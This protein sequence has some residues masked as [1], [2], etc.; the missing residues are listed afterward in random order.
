[1]SRAST[2]AVVH[3]LE[4]RRLL[5]AGDIDLSFGGDGSVEIGATFPVA[6]P[7]VL[8]AGNDK[9]F[10]LTGTSS[11]RLQRRDADGSLDASFGNGGTVELPLTMLTD[12]DVTP[13]GGLV[14]ANELGQF[15]RLNADGSL[16]AAFGSGGI[17]D[18]ADLSPTLAYRAFTYEIALQ[19]D[20]KIIV[21]GGRGFIYRLFA[22]GTLDLSFQPF[23]YSR[24][25]SGWGTIATAPDGKLVLGGRDLAYQGHQFDFVRL[26]SDGIADATFADDGYFNGVQ[27]GNFVVRDD[28]SI[29]AIS[30]NNE[31]VMRVQRI[32]ASGALDPDFD[33]SISSAYLRGEPRFLFQ[34]DGKIILYTDTIM[35]RLNADGSLDDSFGRV[36]THYWD[37]S[38]R[39][40]GAALDAS[41]DIVVAT[42]RSSPGAAGALHRL[43]GGDG[44]ASGPFAVSAGSLTITGTAGD[45][46]IFVDAIGDDVY[47]QTQFGFG[48]IY[49]AG[50]VSN[51]QASLLDGNDKLIF[52]AG[53]RPATASGGDG[54]DTIWGGDGDDSITGGEGRDVLAGHLGDDSLHG[55]G[56]IDTIVGGWGDDSIRGGASA[57][58]ILGQNG[59]DQV[60]GDGGCDFISGGAGADVLHGNGGDDTIVVHIDLAIDQVFGDGGRDLALADEDD[61]L[62][63]IEIR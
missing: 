35:T 8:A 46:G 24:T 56:G 41:G 57:D 27:A 40:R 12:A 9:L 1:M 60:W 31:G 18:V 34:D 42:A 3:P 25:L 15:A 33:V 49:D 47:A 48:Q 28:G 62:S 58:K 7:A 54:N 29:L 10:L 45:D 53:T 22:D 23:D 2:R 16:D 52:H 13:A 43:H 5:S 20:G 30:S 37:G 4:P 6:P 26:S 61:L 11:H 21:M 44:P 39:I 17:V 38:L 63:S 55:D 51:F 36:L 59:N 14:I 19:P 32:T 50:D